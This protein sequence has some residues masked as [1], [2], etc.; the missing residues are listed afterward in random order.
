MHI[1][2]AI[3]N[4]LFKLSAWSRCLNSLKSKQL[5]IAQQRFEQDMFISNC[6]RFH[7]MWCKLR[8]SV[9]ENCSSSKLLFDNWLLFIDILLWNLWY[10]TRI[11]ENASSDLGNIKFTVFIVVVVERMTECG[12]R[13]DNFTSSNNL[14]TRQTFRL[15]DTRTNEC[16]FFEH[17]FFVLISKDIFLN[18][19]KAGNHPHLLELQFCQNKPC[20]NTW[21]PVEYLRNLI[22]DNTYTTFWFLCNRI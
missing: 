15:Y 7:F 20:L 11:A 1:F 22:K 4:L 3:I 16:S 13:I 18:S 19:I 8:Y 2:N 21:I 5:L 17:G 9:S 6:F 14:F 12:S 10:S